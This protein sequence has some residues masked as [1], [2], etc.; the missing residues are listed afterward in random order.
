MEFIWGILAI[1]SGVFVTLSSVMN[2]QAGK[3]IG[4]YGSALLNYLLGTVTA[5]G[6]Y[7][8]LQGPGAVT[9]AQLREVPLW[10]F[11]G[12][13]VGVLVVVGCNITLPRIPII[14]A[15]LLIFIGQCLTGLILDYFDGIVLS[16]GRLLGLLMILGGLLYNLW[17][18]KQAEGQEK[19][20]N[21][22]E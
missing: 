8:V 19:S 15:T 6:I 12:G 7:L 21:E 1:L 18:D 9:L 13:L 14:Y 11:A 22:L 17:V 5:L 10:G 16:R 4:I 3:K 2:A 20:A